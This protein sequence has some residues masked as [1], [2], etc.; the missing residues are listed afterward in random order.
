MRDGMLVHQL[1]PR[2][3]MGDAASNHA[4]AIRDLVRERGVECRIYAMGRDDF[5]KTYGLDQG[6]YLKHMNNPDDLLIYHYLAYC[7]NYRLFLGSRNRKV[8]IYHNITPAEF[9][10]GFDPSTQEVCRMGRKLLPR[11][12]E[13]DLAL[14]DSEFNRREL[15]EMGFPEERTAVLPINPPS[16]LTE[17]P[18]D[19]QMFRRLR[20]G[21][22]NLL[23]VGRVVPNKR[24][25]DLLELFSLY[26]RSVNAYSRLLVVGSLGSPYADYILELV[27]RAHL[28]GRAF[29]LGKVEDSTLKACYLASHFYLSMSE[30]EGFCVPLLEAFQ[31]GLPVMACAAGAVP[32]TMGDAGILFTEKDYPVLAELLETL[33][34]DPLLRERVAAAQRERLEHYGPSVFRQRFQETIGRFLPPGEE[35]G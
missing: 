9:Y 1:L 11:L 2:F 29:F 30:H 28:E 32:E 7:D 33:R 18:V 35:G 23:F 25:E 3:D 14:G 31:F 21:R 5:G 10:E 34:R 16:R 19:K 6:E 4:L 22:C 20:D 24:L 12:A 27:E 15:V 17:A 13:C 8:L 26:H